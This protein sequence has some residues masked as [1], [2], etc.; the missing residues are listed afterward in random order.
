MCSTW[1]DRN[2]V[3]NRPQHTG[4]TTQR[5][6]YIR[7]KICSDWFRKGMSDDASHT[8]YIW[9]HWTND[10]GI[11]MISAETTVANNQT[12][13]YLAV[14]TYWPMGDSD[15]LAICR[16]QIITYWRTDIRMEEDSSPLALR[17]RIGVQKYNILSLNKIV[18]Y[19]QLAPKYTPT[20][21]HARYQK[22]AWFL[23]C[24][25]PLRHSSKYKYNICMYCIA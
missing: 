21:Q 7:I 2:E 8:A 12:C 23:K 4:Y 14:I 25:N 3:D 6:Q 22:Y 19:A 1:N 13:N 16:E 5:Q 24:W 10:Q 18:I 9:I 20:S 17:M 15:V 11:E